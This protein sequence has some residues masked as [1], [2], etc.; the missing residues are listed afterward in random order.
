MSK[1]LFI[2]VIAALTLSA[3]IAPTMADEK[4]EPVKW[5]VN[6]TVQYNAVT[7]EEA[8]EIAE[9]VMRQNEK[10]CSAEFKVKQASSNGD[11]F[12][13]IS[14]GGGWVTQNN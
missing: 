10:A 14:P 11:G 2:I 4:K 5:Q 13:V 12:L 9:R 1:K 6:V 8:L 3:V 7:R